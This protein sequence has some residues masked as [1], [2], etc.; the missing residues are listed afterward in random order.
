[1]PPSAWTAYCGIAESLVNLVGAGGGARGTLLKQSLDHELLAPTRHYQNHFWTIHPDFLV[2]LDGPVRKLCGLPFGVNEALLPMSLSFLPVDTNGHTAN[3]DPGMQIDDHGVDGGGSIQQMGVEVDLVQV[4]PGTEE[5]FLDQ[6]M[7]KPVP[8]TKTGRLPKIRESEA[9][10][11]CME[12]VYTS[13]QVAGIDASTPQNQTIFDRISFDG[14]GTSSMETVELLFTR[15]AKFL[16]RLWK[17]EWA[18]MIADSLIM[19]QRKGVFADH[20]QLVNKKLRMSLGSIYKKSSLT[21]FID[22]KLGG[23]W[24]FG[25]D[26]QQPYHDSSPLNGSGE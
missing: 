2:R 6:H 17:I 11:N 16:I 9:Y 12:G 18:G 26:E 3:E 14:I 5:A 7:A 8:L 10:R 15:I 22:D 1:V 23:V 21:Q 25:G 13:F 20:I 19:K 24:P 4:Y